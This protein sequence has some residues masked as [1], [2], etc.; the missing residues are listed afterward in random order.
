MSRL[1]KHANTLEEGWPILDQNLVWTRPLLDLP[2]SGP[3]GIG[4]MRC[5]H[6]RAPLIPI[7]VLLGKEDK[8]RTYKAIQK[9][10]KNS[11][12]NDRLDSLV[13][14]RSNW[15]AVNRTSWY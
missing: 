15:Y 11:V 13:L 8:L 14:I 5:I 6:G 3:I 7:V 10:V 1:S 2:L 12:A 4:R 9:G